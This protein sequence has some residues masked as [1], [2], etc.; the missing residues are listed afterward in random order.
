MKLTDTSYKVN[1]PLPSRKDQEALLEALLDGTIDMLATDHAPHT[2]EEKTNPFDEAPF[3]IN[4]LEM[5][6]AAVWQELVLTGK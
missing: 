1:P 5:V 6:L 3:G 2:W 4:A